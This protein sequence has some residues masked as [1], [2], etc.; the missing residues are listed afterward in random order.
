MHNRCLL[1]LQVITGRGRHSA[2]GVARILPAVLRYLTEAGY[3]FSEEQNNPGVICIP[4]AGARRHLLSYMQ[5]A[6]HQSALT[7]GVNQ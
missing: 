2:G 7:N 5:D 1:A 4:L 6:S 3:Q